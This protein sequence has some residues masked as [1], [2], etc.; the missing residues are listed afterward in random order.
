MRELT[1][2]ATKIKLLQKKRSRDGINTMAE[3]RDIKRTFTNS[4]LQFKHESIDQ[5]L[6]A[7]IRTSHKVTCPNVHE[8]RTGQTLTPL[9]SGK[10]QYTQMLK[11]HNMQAVRNE[12]ITRGFVFDANIRYTA[13]IQLIKEKEDDSK[14]FT[15]LTDYD[16]F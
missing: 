13:M 5:K 6:A 7:V 14:Y 12:S 4:T 9:I 2:T 15:P 16:S 8:R 11:V 10:I 3:K 1:K